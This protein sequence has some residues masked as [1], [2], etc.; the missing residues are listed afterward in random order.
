MSKYFLKIILFLFLG[1][2]CT[3]VIH[4]ST[5]DVQTYTVQ[6]ST[7]QLYDTEIANLIE[8]YK[9]KLDLEM[10]QVIGSCPQKL[11][12]DAPQ[13]TL[14]NWMADA[15]YTQVQEQ[16]NEK[17][18]FAIQ[19]QGGVRVVY[20]PKG[21]ITKGNIFELMPF[22][23]RVVL[24][25]MKGNMIDTLFTHI[26][27]LGGWPVS[28]EVHYKLINGQVSNIQIQGKPLDSEATYTFAL[29]DYIANGGDNCSFL[30]KY[31][32]RVDSEILIRDLLIEHIK[33]N[34]TIQGVLDNRVQ[35]QQN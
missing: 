19:N 3:K 25:T 22:E 23:N 8:P 28:Q 33:S 10:N 35:T 26:G 6:D 15:I 4:Q 9:Q 2:S 17:I 32:N 1:T 14:G 11:E 12:K 34:P 7:N 16:L 31:I 21:D 27:G 13:S 18:D 29:P 24:L 30:S 20:L 5:T